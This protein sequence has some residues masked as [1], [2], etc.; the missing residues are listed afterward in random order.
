MSH[1]NHPGHDAPQSQEHGHNEP[2]N[3]TH[4]HDEAGHEQ[5][6][7]AVDKTKAGLK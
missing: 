7:T 6:H 5:A 4:E 3:T 1:H 2:A